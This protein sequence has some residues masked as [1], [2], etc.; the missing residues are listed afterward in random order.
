[1]NKFDAWANDPFNEQVL[2][3]FSPSKSRMF[4]YQLKYACIG[5]AA[6]LLAGFI[7]ALTDVILWIG[8]L[9]FGGAAFITFFIICLSLSRQG[10]TIYTITE[11]KIIIYP[12]MCSADFTN[13]KR[14]KKSRS[15]FNRNV[16]T[17]KFKLKKGLSANYR[18]VKIDDVDAVYDLLISLW[19]KQQ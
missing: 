19:E 17:I 15:L 2:W 13:I 4:F 11:T 18:F 3:Q 5:P 9:L 6:C 12:L 10:R 16:G 14:I 8:L 7:L 1:M